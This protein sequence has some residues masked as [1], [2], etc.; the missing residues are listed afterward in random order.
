MKMIHRLLALLFFLSPLNLVGA[1]YQIKDL[2][3]LSHNH[4]LASGINNDNV[5]VGMTESTTNFNYIWN[6]NNGLIL[7]P[8][9]TTYQSPYINNKNEIVGLYWH[10]TN[11]WFFGNKSSKHIFLLRP[12]GFFQDLETPSKWDRQLLAGSEDSFKVWDK[13]EIGIIDFNDRGQILIGNSY[14]FRKMTEFAIWE[15]GEFKYLEKDGLEVAYGINNEGVLLGRKC[16]SEGSIPMLVLYDPE[17]N[18]TQVVGEADSFSYGVHNDEGQVALLQMNFE[19]HIVKGFVW[20]ICNGL[21]ELNNFVPIDLNNR[22]QMIGVQARKNGN[23][24][25]IIPSIWKEG[26]VINL[27]DD[28]KIGEDD[29]PWSKIEVLTS[30]ND[31]GYIIGQGVYN[32]KKHAFVLIP[33]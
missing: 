31:N 29:S 2:G 9:I 15:E 4:S 30:I 20:D 17:N 5:I 22:G 26:E 27:I 14:V 33:N 16:L 12:D 6:P 3:T 25:E 23:V 18:T 32:D 13:K 24:E 7:L 28:L 1:H 10:K 11:Y 21:V 8:Y 19:L